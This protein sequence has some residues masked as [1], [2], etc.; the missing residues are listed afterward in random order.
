MASN[1][2][3]AA[4][5]QGKSYYATLLACNF[6]KENKVVFTNYPIIYTVPLK[7]FQ[8]IANIIAYILYI[9]LLIK[10]YILNCFYRYYP[11]KTLILKT[12]YKPQYK[13]VFYNIILSTNVWKDEYVD[14]G[15]H[16]CVVILD[17]AYKIV[18]CH[19]KMTDNQHDFWATSGHN[20]VDIY[21]IAQNYRRINIVIRELS[22]FIIISKFSNPFSLL[23]KE[24][25]KQ[26]TP[27]IFSISTYL[28]ESDYMFKTIRK[29][30]LY[31]KKRVL[32]NT[33][34]ANAYNTQQYRREEKKIE[35]ETWLQKMKKI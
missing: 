21:V 11:K 35:I 6:L 3:S 8:K 20:N 2:I 30:A 4:P 34:I 31:D 22:T 25:R 29:D 28:S 16:D 10:W 18:N 7:L 19:N 13:P 23:S 9:L 32:F 14:F 17:E 26:L 27:F 15:L 33:S 5:S 1:I 12:R 24:G